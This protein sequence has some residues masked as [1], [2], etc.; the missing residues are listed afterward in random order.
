MRTLILSLTLIHFLFL[1]P[2]EAA[3]TNCIAFCD[4][5]GAGNPYA[6]PVFEAHYHESPIQG[7][8]TLNPGNLPP[9]T[10]LYI[11]IG[12]ILKY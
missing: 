7:Q 2:L 10:C 5:G 1:M 11:V 9:A 6:A 3:Q 8:T 12:C 4:E